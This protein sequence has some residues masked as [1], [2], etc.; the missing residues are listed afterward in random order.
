MGLTSASAIASRVRLRDPPLVH[1]NR[2]MKTLLSI[3]VVLLLFCSVSFAANP[4]FQDFYGTNGIVIRTN[5]N[6]VQVDGSALASTNNAVVFTNLVHTNVTWVAKNGDNTTGT[7]GNFARPYLSIS[8]AVQASPAGTLVVVEPGVYN[9]SIRLKNMVNL[10]M[11]SGVIVTQSVNLPVIIDGNTT[12]TSVISGDFLLYHGADASQTDGISCFGTDTDLTLYGGTINIVGSSDYGIEMGRGK[13]KAERTTIYTGGHGVSNEKAGGSGGVSFI[14]TIYA[15]NNAAFI[16]GGNAASNYLRGYFS[17]EAYHAIQHTVGYILLEDSELISFSA[18]HQTIDFS[19]GDLEV[20]RGKIT[21]TD[22]EP[23]ISKYGNGFMILDGVQF[24]AGDN[25]NYAIDNDGDVSNGTTEIRTALWANKPIRPD[26]TILSNGFTRLSRYLSITTNDYQFPAVQGAF[27]TFLKNDG[28]GGL[29]WSSNLSLLVVTNLNVIN[30]T[31]LSNVNVKGDLI[32]TN[33]TMGGAS[34]R[35]NQYT[36]NISGT[37]VIGPFW[38]STTNGAPVTNGPRQASIEYIPVMR[39]WRQGDVGAQGPGHDTIDTQSVS[40]YWN[41]TNQGF[42]S[43]AFGSNNW[44]W[45]NYSIIGNGMFNIIGSNAVGSS[46][47]GGSNNVIHTNAA[48]S[49]I[50]GGA[51]NKIRRDS[52]FSTIGGGNNNLIRSSS[53]AQILGGD[54]HNILSAHHG[55]VVGGSNNLITSTPYSIIGGGAGNTI[56]NASG[57]GNVIGGGTNNLIDLGVWCFIGGGRNNTINASTFEATIGGGLNN[58]VQAGA[59]GSAILGGWSN[60][61]SASS[62]ALG[63]FITNDTQQ[64][65]QMGWGA[66]YNNQRKVQVNPHGL[67]IVNFGSTNAVGGTMRVTNTVVFSAGAAETNLQAVTINAHTL[68]NNQERLL[69]RASGRFA[70]TSNTKTIKVVYGSETIFDSTA[71]VANTGAWVLNGEIIRTGSTSQSCNVD[72]NGGTNVVFVR[73][74]SLDTAQTNGIATVLKITSTAAGDGDVT[75]RTF[76]VEW[77]SAP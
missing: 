77:R 36:T 75:N 15:T 32:I 54:N 26:I 4:A 67:Q 48:F 59:N 9:E 18:G 66:T 19:G 70:A 58:L 47:L 23:P 71:G 34:L 5:G 45:G 7:P 69:F 11:P 12:V 62:V 65:V 8:N 76:T 61:T 55:T 22:D 21:S 44:A 3:P 24:V 40:N 63:S 39:T 14:G 57:I 56:Q 53:F 1:T 33:I 2:L 43:V 73:T 49:F 46:I 41:A 68:T 20:R 6:K 35:T 50:G 74:S 38:F 52:I 10:Y 72:F 16:D 37:P 51:A 17:S 28:S 13:L 30:T 29:S 25:A 31:V 42:G 27:D 60:R 64:S